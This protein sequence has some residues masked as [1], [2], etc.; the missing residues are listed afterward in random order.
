MLGVP[1][2][3]A[4]VLDAVTG[5]YGTFVIEKRYGFNKTTPA[6]YFLD[7][8]KELL[9]GGVL[10]GGLFSLFLLLHGLIG[11]WVFFAFFFI[12]IAFQLFMA[13]IS[14]LMRRVF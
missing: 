5:I 2:F 11:D 10:M 8:V 3:V 12:L 14:P 9:I 4:A 1:I 7:F 6:T 13:F